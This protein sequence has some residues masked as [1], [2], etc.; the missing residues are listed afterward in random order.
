MEMI[1]L[2]LNENPFG[3]PLDIIKRVLENLT[4][5]DIA[6]YHD[7]PTPE[8]KRCLLSYIKDTTRTDFIDEHWITVTSGSDE[9]IT[10]LMSM[11]PK[12]LVFFPPTYFWYYTFAEN[13][14]LHYEEF[15][16]INDMGIP[17]VELRRD[18]MVFIPNPNNPTGH[19]FEEEELERIFKSGATVVVD[20][21]YFEFSWISSI[22]YLK[23]YDNLIILRTFS[24]AFAFAGQRFGYAIAHPKWI[25][26][27]EKFKQPYNVG[28]LTQMLVIESLKNRWLFFGRIKE[29]EMERERLKE[30]LER[31]GFNV[32]P[33][34]TNFLYFKT[35]NAR[36]LVKELEKR[37]ILVRELWNGI[38]V[39]IGKKFE[40]DLFIKTLSELISRGEGVAE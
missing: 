23:K 10:I 25:E 13:M 9:G 32:F 35:K 22:K 11:R 4:E 19:L 5:E 20:E 40:N 39:S 16:L 24:K 18:D 27:M 30:A 28:I 37:G 26:K 8:L 2:N 29:I 15:P 12:R 17:E 33:S 14:N 3:F 36:G 34:Y 31:L 7:T 38:R 1:R 6:R 21:A